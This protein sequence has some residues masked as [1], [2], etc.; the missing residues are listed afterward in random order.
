MRDTTPQD[1]LTSRF[2]LRDTRISTDNNNTGVRLTFILSQETLA[3][4]D[5][6]IKFSLLP[7]P[8]ISSW[9]TENLLST[10]G[11]DRFLAP[12]GLVWTRASGSFVSLVF[13]S[14][15]LAEILWGF[16]AGDCWANN[17]LK[18]W[19]EVFCFCGPAGPLLLSPAQL[20]LRLSAL[21]RSS[22][23]ETLG[24]VGFFLPPVEL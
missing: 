13:S 6:S 8:S 20:C 18:S 4:P 15:S 19:R 24:A 1:S 12:P 2:A 14:N 17:F 3:R 23:R 7:P 11:E 21:S 16:W 9:M 22:S 10:Q 5:Y